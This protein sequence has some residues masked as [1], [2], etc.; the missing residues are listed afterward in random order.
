MIKLRPTKWDGGAKSTSGSDI[1]IGPYDILVGKSKKLGRIAT[2][3]FFEVKQ[4][5][6][7]DIPLPTMPLLSTRKASAGKSEREQELDAILN[8]KKTVS[9]SH[10]VLA[11][12][13]SIFPFAFFPDTIIV[14]R[15]KITIV[16]SDFFFSS[17]TISIRIEDVLNVSI[18]LGPIFGTL[19]ISSRVMNS[20]DHFTIEHFRRADAIHLK[21]LIQGYM[22]AQHNNISTSHLSRE[23]L[24]DT[25]CELGSD[26]NK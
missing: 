10:E 14:D 20:T 3:A 22:I 12:A 8:L 15:T 7:K 2:Q 5:L 1:D 17:N 9:Q 13:R 19:T 16:K 26:S 25:L 11:K 18:G 6:R 21:H 24:I 4:F 23:E